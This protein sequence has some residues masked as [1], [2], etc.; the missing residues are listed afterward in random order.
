[1]DF[2]GHRRVQLLKYL[3]MKL[4]TSRIC[5]Q[6]IGEWWWVGVQIS[7]DWPWVDNYQSSVVGLGEG[8]FSPLLYMSEIFHNKELFKG[9]EDSSLIG[10]AE[11]SRNLLW[12]CRMRRVAGLCLFTCWLTKAINNFAAGFPANP[13]RQKHPTQALSS[14]EKMNLS[15]S[16]IDVQ[17]CKGPWSSWAVAVY[18]KEVGIKN[19][20]TGPLL[21]TLLQ[22]LEIWF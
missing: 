8:Q 9:T 1:M 6:I 2:D 4:M 14:E 7:H 11:K 3:Q 17:S 19:W 10:F 16:S 18:H 12:P 20:C 5:F 15:M 21:R 22:R 13:V